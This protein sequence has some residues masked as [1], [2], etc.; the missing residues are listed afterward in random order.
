MFGKA[1]WSNWKLIATTEIQ[2]NK[3]QRGQYILLL[4]T[5]KFKFPTFSVKHNKKERILF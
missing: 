1:Q 3:L 4:G 2:I 5:S